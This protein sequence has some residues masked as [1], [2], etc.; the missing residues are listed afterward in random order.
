MG[1]L[2]THVLDTASGKPAAGIVI[3]LFNASATNKALIKTVTSN[4]DGRV[5][6]ALLQ[7][8]DF[9][10]GRYRLEFDVAA[11]F[12]APLDK[13]KTNSDPAA[14]N[15]LTHQS[16]IPFL[17]LVPIEFGVADSEQNYHIPL[18][19]SPWSYSTYRGS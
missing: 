5:D 3:R 18:L 17:D 10:P 16:A 9:K 12:R 11:Y 6:G 15:T 14:E 13:H 8:Q 2:S 19:I 7:D 4:A 1:K